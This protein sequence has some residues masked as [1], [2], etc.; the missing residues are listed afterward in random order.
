MNKIS[1]A[2]IAPR[3]AALRPADRCSEIILCDG[4]VL[5]D[6]RRIRSLVTA[7]ARHYAVDLVALRQLCGQLL[8]RRNYLPLPLAAGLLLVPLPLAGSPERVGYVNY[9]CIESIEKTDTPGIKLTGGA[10]VN[11]FLSRATLENRLLAARYAGM[12][13]AN[14][15]C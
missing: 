8:H 3:L 10:E 5:E 13:W 11:C 6:C 15:R 14:W 7:L 12:A 1:I 4:T 2:S 9:L